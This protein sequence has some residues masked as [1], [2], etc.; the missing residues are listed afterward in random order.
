MLSTV[1]RVQSK[2]TEYG[3]AWSA[4]T[5]TSFVFPC[6]ERDISDW[7]A[8]NV[9][10]VLV[11]CDTKRQLAYWKDVTSRLSHWRTDG[12]V[13]GTVLGRPRPGSEK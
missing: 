8:S 7:V 12:K 1:F 3:R 10:V 13:L 2:A 9:P 11:C 4:E 5:E 6:K